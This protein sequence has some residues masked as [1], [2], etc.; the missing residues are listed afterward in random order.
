[1]KNRILSLLI[2]TF[3][4]LMACGQNTYF[5]PYYPTLSGVDEYAA[6]YVSYPDSLLWRYISGEAVCMIRIDRHGQVTDRQIEATHPL[7]AQAAGEVIDQMTNWQP[8][9]LNGIAID[10]TVV[11]RIPFDPDEY[12]ERIWRQAQV[13]EPCRGQYVDRKPLFP[14]KVRNLV[15]GNMKWPDP[16]VQTAVSVCRFTVNTDGCV[17]NIRVLKG[18]HPLFDQEAVRI[19]SNFPLLIPAQKDGLPVSYDYFLTINFWKLDLEYELRYREKKRKDIENNYPELCSQASYPGGT[20]ALAL[21][22]STHL[23]ITPEMKE[24]GKQGRV[25]YSFEVDLNGKM[26]NFELLRGL[27]PLMDAEALRILQLADRTWERG[28]CFN[29]KKWYKEFN[30]E[31]RF[32]MPVIFKW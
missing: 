18:T 24:K 13:L 22:V 8:A 9:L 15:M 3:V 32:T 23:N 16:K 26:T 4:A 7:F 21:F 2:S 14:D 20:A 1:M 30:T 10:T 6:W 31:S 12:N 27:H 25:I 28:Y 29:I 17:T 19:L 5:P 11:I